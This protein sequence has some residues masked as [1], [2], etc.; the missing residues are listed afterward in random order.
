[1]KPGTMN[2]GSI[3]AAVVCVCAGASLAAAGCERVAGPGAPGPGAATE[4][5]SDERPLVELFSWWSAPGEA[6][7][8]EALIDV[9]RRQHPGARI[10]NA[11]AASG[12]AARELLSR[13]LRDHDPPDL[14][15][16]YV[17][18]L[19]ATVA[20]AAGHQRRLDDLFDE[21]RLR[22]LVYPEIL[23]D[24]T[25]DGHLFAMPVN[26]HRENTLFFNRRLFA[27]HGVAPPSTL[28]ELLEACRKLKA[29]GVTPVATAHQGWILRIMFN[30][31]AIGKMGSA[32][33]HDYFSGARVDDVGPLREAIHVFAQVL[34]RYTNVDAGDEGY[35]W[36]SAAQAV[37]NG[38]AAMVLHG[39]WVKGYLQELGWRP[40]VDF[41]MVAA[42]G[43]RDL[44]L[45]GVDAFALPVGARNERGARE[46]LRTVASTEGQIA[47]NRIKGSSPVR[48][49]VP[50]EWFDSAGLATL[51]DLDHAR[52][53][54][55]VRSRPAW[56]DA[57]VAFAKSHDERALLQAFV[58][59][60]P[61]PLDR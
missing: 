16:E 48:H 43:T 49:D 35:G 32:R 54:M 50:R 41:G 10:F 34:E 57:M 25:S 45:Y 46:L 38:D 28:D 44:F 14:F 4:P 40:D 23:H 61:S 30:A 52:I 8:L 7:A 60:P 42:P 21:L 3:A 12:T 51:D 20:E 27:A 18:D 26:V 29:A 2:R 47:F 56:E 24:V 1:M 59:A 31:L 5:A 33:Y 53:R 22:E 11:A 55:L 6:E 13:R 39:D 17:H 19:R 15:Q 37:Y 58:D 9:H 36:T